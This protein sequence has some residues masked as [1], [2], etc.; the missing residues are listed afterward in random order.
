MR[1]L[2]MSLTGNLIHLSIMVPRLS[3]PAKAATLSSKEDTVCGGYVCES[4]DRAIQQVLD[5]VLVSVS[6][7]RVWDIAFAER[8]WKD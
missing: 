5:V 7:H 2:E 8:A 1:G 4:I 3:G 6:K